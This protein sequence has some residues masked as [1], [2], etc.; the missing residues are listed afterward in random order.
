MAT[1]R[2]QRPTRQPLVDARHIRN[3]VARLNQVQG[4]TDADRDRAWR[5][6]RQAARRHGVEIHERGRR[7]LLHRSPGRPT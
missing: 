1:T 7:Q 2:P 3:A 4:V 6:I 5:R